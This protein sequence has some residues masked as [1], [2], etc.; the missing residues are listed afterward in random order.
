M[1][2]QLILFLQSILLGAALGLLYDFLRAI[3]R[4]GGGELLLTVLDGLYAIASACTIFFFVM[5]GDGELRLFV[6][7]GALGGAILHFCLFSGPMAPLWDFWLGIFL[8]PWKFMVNIMKKIGTFCKKLFSFWKRWFTIIAT[9]V[10]RPRR[11]VKKKGEEHMVK[12]SSPNRGTPA[13]K[14]KAPRRRCGKLT[15]LL[16]FVLALGI[17]YQLHSMKSTLASAREEEAAYAQRLEELRE[18]NARLSMEIANSSDQELLENIARNELGMAA[19]G[20]KIF[21]F[22]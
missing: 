19:P 11:R 14:E 12:K 16:L 17:V 22:N 13:K 21:R 10:P 6:L 8:L 1:S 15:M 20:E 3:R 2:A 18:T 4:R 7:L 5:A 9:R